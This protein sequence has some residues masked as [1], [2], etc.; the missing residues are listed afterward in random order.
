MNER[1][2][3]SSLLLHPWHVLSVRV[4]LRQASELTLTLETLVPAFISGLTGLSSLT[5][6][7]E[8]RPATQPAALWDTSMR[9]WVA[10]NSAKSSIKHFHSLIQKSRHRPGH[11]WPN[12]SKACICNFEHTYPNVNFDTNVS[13]P[14]ALI[15]RC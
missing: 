9:N 2:D 15:V 5:L 10:F 12:E 13:I 4:T 6:C 1:H 11:E 14:R 3:K 8:Y 7:G